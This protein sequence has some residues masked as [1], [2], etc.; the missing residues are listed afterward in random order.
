MKSDHRFLVLLIVT[1]FYWV[2]QSELGAEAQDG[3]Y[4]VVWVVDGDTIR[5][6]TDEFVRYIGI[7]TPEIRRK[8][9]GRWKYDPDPFGEDAKRFNMKLVK[10]QVVRLEF[11]VQ[12]KD[13][14][15]RLLA[16]VYQDDV[17]VNLELVKAGYAK[18]F[19]KSPNVKYVKEFRRA[20]HE[21]KKNKR[22]LW[23]GL[24]L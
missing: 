5:I 23:Q 6:N 4:Q 3:E 2:C 15:G 21:A 19:T 1:F 10:G 7:D 22:G 17:F 18:L 13:K 11:D 9:R 24:D 12:K 14:Y 20:L 8:V 16:Y